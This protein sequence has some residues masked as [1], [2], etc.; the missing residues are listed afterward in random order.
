MNVGELIVKLGADLY[1]YNRDLAQAEKQA[2]AT[3]TKIGDIFRNALSFGL[4]MGIF[5]AIQQGFRAV[6]GEA[7]DFNSMMEQARIGF[8]TML[9]SAE[10]AQAFLKEMGKFAAKTPFEYPDLLEASRRMMAM[11][12]AAEEVLPT[13]KAVGDAAAGLGV[14]SEGVNR[15]TYAL[16]QMRTAGRLN[17]QDMM[18]LTS[19]GVEAWDYVAEA[20]GVSVAEAR[21]M[22]EKGLIPTDKA[23][24][25]IISGMERDFPDMMKKMENTWA[26]VTSTIKD[27]WRM[28]VGALTKDLFAGLVNWLKGIRDFATEFYAT[29]Q[30]IGLRGALVKYFGAEFVV[31]INMA[32][33]AL[34]GLWNVAATVISGMIKYWAVLKPLIITT[35]IAFLSFRVVTG[36]LAQ[37]TFIMAVMRGEAVATS[38]VLNFVARAVQIYQVQLALASAAGVAH[39]GVLQVLR[40]ALYSV[41]AAMGPLGWAII[42]VSAAVTAGIALWSKY[43]ASVEKSN[44]QQVLQAVSGKQTQVAQSSQKV[45]QSSQQAAQ[46][47]ENQT[48]ATK[49]AGKAVQDNLQGFDELHKLTKDTAQSAEDAASSLGQVGLPASPEVGG[50]AAPS[51]PNL[52]QM[53]DAQKPTLVGFWKWMV[54]GLADMWEGVKVKWNAFWDWVKSWG[55]WDW[56]AK[57][58][59]SV[60]DWAGNAWEGVKRA[61]GNFKQWVNGWATALWNGV[62][63]SWKNFASWAVGLWQ[64]VKTAWSNFG[65]WVGNLWSAIRA[66]AGQ[67]WNTMRLNIQA[68][69][70]SLCTFLQAVWAGI[71]SFLQSTWGSI[72]SNAGTAW[73][74]IK[75]TIQGVTQN[76]GSYLTSTWKNISSSLQSIWAVI[77]SNASPVWAGISSAIQNHMSS[78]RGSLA[79]IWSGISS[80]LMSAWDSLCSSA[81]RMFQR[82]ADT[83][84]NI[85]R[86]IHIPMPHLKLTAKTTTIAGKKISYPDIDVDWYAKGGIFT[87]PSVIGVGEAGPEA[88]LPLSDSGWMDTLASRIASSIKAVGSGDVYVYIGNEQVDAYIYRSQDRRT[89]RSNGR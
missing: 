18:Q 6:V 88:V 59:Q 32:I 60:C 41:W 67:E 74:Y 84:R 29:F 56:L 47:M 24:H 23:L 20:I 45:A 77:R 89:I 53:L 78:L 62:K 21:K 46:G 50:F 70:N 73:S 2:K 38:A 35:V 71:S 54:Q 52:G 15:I 72:K 22:S 16:G 10:K 30:Q 42:G 86:N 69:V 14:G 64:D 63:V 49:K 31:T 1:Q 58:W 61:W 9:G 85:F 82:I 13:L 43:A 81:T 48:D 7:I 79:N 57:K 66:K 33:S 76:L 80:T 55:L 8:T 28:T 44:L 12:F 19:V 5:Q 51:L 17:A 68:A 3:G 37:L 4:G 75:T 25:A 11:G 39:V 65:A 87:Q 27:V 40:T 26:G 34:K 83:I 36:V